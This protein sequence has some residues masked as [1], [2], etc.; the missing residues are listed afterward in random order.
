M[1]TIKILCVRGVIMPRKDSS[2]E[3][4]VKEHEK[5]RRQCDV[6]IT[7]GKKLIAFSIA[8]AALLTWCS[9]GFWKIGAGIV[10]ISIGNTLL[11][12]WGYKKHD[13]AIKQLSQ[14][15]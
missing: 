9:F 13:K 11:E 6:R 10:V 7:S 14:N 5:Y 8:L 12:Y 4:K 1:R 2:I 3:S 15:T